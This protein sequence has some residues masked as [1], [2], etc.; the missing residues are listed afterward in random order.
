[1]WVKGV[2]ICKAPRSTP[3]VVLY[4]CLLS[5]KSRRHNSIPSLEMIKSL[6]IALSKLRGILRFPEKQW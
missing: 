1:M 2:N 5:K 4:K 3:G 6:A